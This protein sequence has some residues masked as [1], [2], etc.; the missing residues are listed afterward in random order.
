MTIETGKQVRETWIEE[1]LYLIP[2][3]DRAKIAA[4]FDFRYVSDREDVLKTEWIINEYSKR[5]GN[6]ENTFDDE[7]REILATEL[8]CWSLPRKVR[9]NVS[10]SVTSKIREDFQWRLEGATDRVTQLVDRMQYL[11]MKYGLHL[12]PKE[13]VILQAVL[14]GVEVEP[15]LIDN[16][17]KIFLDSPFYEAG[18]KE[19]KSLY[20]KLKEANYYEL[21]ATIESLRL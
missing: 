17:A 6:G 1:Q 9:R 7:I 3:M 2:F 13:R 19:A 5:N 18:E 15:V 21:L 16:L 10:L 4:E 11:S 14:Q 20:L 8:N 12:E